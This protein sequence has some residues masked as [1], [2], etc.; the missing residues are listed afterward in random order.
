MIEP[1]TAPKS[2]DNSME[3]DNAIENDNSPDLIREQT[4]KKPFIHFSFLLFHP[5]YHQHD[6]QDQPRS[7]PAPTIIKTNQ[8]QNHHEHQNLH[9]KPTPQTPHQTINNGSKESPDQS[10]PSL[11]LSSHFILTICPQL[12]KLIT[13][14]RRTAHQQAVERARALPHMHRP[15]NGRFKRRLRG[16]VLCADIDVTLANRERRKLGRVEDGGRRV[17]LWGEGGRCV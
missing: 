7:K 11:P 17:V 3:L 12:G 15:G 14:L 6:Y 8:D 1:I 9:I 5:P 10:T 4:I 2:H 16:R 13:T